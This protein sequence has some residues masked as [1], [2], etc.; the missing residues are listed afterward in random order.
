LVQIIQTAKREED[1]VSAQQLLQQTYEQSSGIFDYLHQARME[2]TLT[3][4]AIKRP[5]ST[6]AFNQGENT[7]IYSKVFD[8]LK[9]YADN[10]VKEF[11]NLSLTEFLSYPRVIGEFIL[12]DCSKRQSAKI[13]VVD[14]VIK[15][16]KNMG[17]K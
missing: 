14:G 1:Y 8:T 3:E 4:P 2:Q 12:K 13:G 15:E 6:M 9:A 16:M 11:Y 10:N 7:Y 17:E 5:L